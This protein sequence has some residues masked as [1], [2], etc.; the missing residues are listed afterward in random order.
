MQ[1]T[2]RHIITSLLILLLSSFAFS[3]NQEVKKVY[4]FGTYNKSNKI[5]SGISFG[6]F[7][8]KNLT[9]STTNGIRLELLGQGVG[10]LFISKF[11]NN[12]QDSLNLYLGDY[13]EKINGISFSLL[14]LFGT[15]KVN[16]INIGIYGNKLSLL[17]GIGITASINMGEKLNGISLAGILN[18]YKIHNGLVISGIS[19]IGHTGNGLEMSL[20]TNQTRKFNGIKISLFNWAHSGN[21]VQ[22]GLLNKIDTNPK[23]CRLLPIINIGKK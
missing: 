20:F 4:P 18:E 3:Q 19:N 6:V 8:S 5:T 11:V 17:N 16:G 1:F 23:W 15:Q 12:K 2:I 13:T 9:N 7:H 14:G 22:L 21:L 10:T